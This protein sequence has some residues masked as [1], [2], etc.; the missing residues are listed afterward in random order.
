MFP[1]SKVL[2]DKGFWPCI[3]ITALNVNSSSGGLGRK[4]LVMPERKPQNQFTGNGLQGSVPSSPKPDCEEVQDEYTSIYDA[5]EMDTRE[6]IDI[7][8][9]NFTGFPHSKSGNKQVLATM[10]R[11]VESLV[12]KHEL[13]YKGMIARLNLE[14]KGE[15]V[16]FVK[17]VATE[18]F[19]DGITNWGRI[20]SLLTFGAMVSKHQNDKGLSKCVSL[21]G[22]EISSYLLTTQRDWLLKNKA[23]DGFVEFFHVPNTEAAVR[24][25]LMA[26]GSVATFGAA[27][28]Y[29]TR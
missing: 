17:T 9:K 10:N 16:S 28:A 29:L 14:Q 22:K 15:D 6:I 4:P 13:V 3:G 25:T 2:N 23:W 18:L 21:V 12:M 1:G 20:A 26:I 7:F 19:S 27:L 5:L 8:L 24:N 11:V